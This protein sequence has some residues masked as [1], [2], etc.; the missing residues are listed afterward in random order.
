[1]PDPNSIQTEAVRAALARILLWQGFADSPQ[2]SRFL[3]HVVEQTL[4]GN[5]AAIKEYSLGLEVFNRAASFDPKSDSIVRSEARRLRTKLAEYYHDEGAHDP[6]RIDVPKGGYL[7]VF[8]PQNGA[9]AVAP[10]AIEPAVQVGKPAARWPLGAALAALVLMALA[11]GYYLRKSKPKPPEV[12]VRRSL[13]VLA[14]DNRSGRADDAWLSGAIGGILNTDL[15]ADRTLRTIPGED[16]AHMEKD[17]GLDRKPALSRQALVRIR[18]YLGAD[19]L[20]SGEYEVLAP[21]GGERGMRIQIDLRLQNVRTG[22]TIKAI[23]Q[24]GSEDGLFDLVS[25]AGA[26]LR[27]ALGMQLPS[28]A[29]AGAMRNAGPSTP[30]AQRLYYDGLDRLRAYEWAPARDLL[31][32]AADSDPTFPLVHTALSEVWDELVYVQRS[33]EEA[34]T[35][36]D[37][38]P[39]LPPDDRLLVEARYRA[40]SGEWARAGQIYQDLFNRNPDNVEYGLRLA[41]A[42]DHQQK[43]RAVLATIETLRRLPSPLG[44]DPRI[45]LAEGAAY[46][47]QAKHREALVAI[48]NAE[49]KARAQGARG[50]LWHALHD[51]ATNL[52]ALGQ[53]AQARSLSL[54]ASQI[55]AGLGDRICVARS[56]AQIGILDLHTNLK[57]AEKQ[58]QESYEIARREGSFYVANALSNLGGVLEMEG[59]YAR[60]ERALSE[61][62]Q[63]TE[64]AHNTSFLVRVT[65]NRGNLLL[66][67]GNLRAAEGMFRKAIALIG[68]GDVKEWLADSQ[69]DLAQVLELEGDLAQSMKFRQQ[70]LAQARASQAGVAG[71]LV[72]VARLL[73]IRG[74]L[75]AARQTLDQ[76][77]AEAKKTG[78][79]DLAAENAEFAELALEEGRAA[80]GEALALR[81]E[82]RARK[83]SRPSDA[84]DACEILARCL[85]AEGNVL[86]A[87]AA[88]ARAWSY[89]GER[90]AADSLF[91][92]SLTAARVQAATG[93][94]K[95]RTNVDAAIRRVDSVLAAARKD[96]FAGVQLEARLAHGE[97][98]IQSGHTAEARAEL[99]ALMK[100]AT[101]KGYGLLARKA[102]HLLTP[103]F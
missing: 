97:I 33:R 24:N 13:A 71:S 66:L 18:R 69:T 11:A 16:V 12:H 14:L 52:Q 43:E 95:G 1:M 62:S 102:S 78:E 46:G 48:G 9:A 37:L 45:D 5:G 38:S 6:L 53:V 31:V 100:D 50:L 51:E 76:A 57:E 34:K 86:A 103:V 30:E 63:A 91:N 8:S 4:G 22:E 96:G 60:A 25:A 55:C 17:L 58:F 35:A 54:Q 101:T 72:G 3:R 94:Y 7:P 44:D 70:H 85:L 21:S 92:I 36:F 81:I 77:D 15:G 83:E 41:G 32:K 68:E 56:L 27:H 26:Q 84:A 79:N 40:A 88:I 2:L 49:R 23:A 73:S 61:A 59:D 87:Q 10:P 82:E 20:V 39:N 98:R 19:L 99:S 74:D 28:A 29:G 42:L 47:R 65:I 75:R 67:E 64:E 80:A 89:L 93:D 90:K